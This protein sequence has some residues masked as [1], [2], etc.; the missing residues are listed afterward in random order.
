MKALTLSLIII[1]IAITGII[2][3]IVISQTI[4]H[5]TIWLSAVAVKGS[6]D[7]YTTVLDNATLDKIPVLKNAIDQARSGYLP[8]SLCIGYHG[9]P[10]SRTSTIQIR[11]SDVDSILQLVGNK[12][13]TSVIQENP[14]AEINFATYTYK[15]KFEFGNLSYNTTIEK[16]VYHNS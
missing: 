1:G 3:F 9:C 5:V 16:T 4:T 15:M 10:S 12:V 14:S 2:S 7:N 11:Q 13:K 6:D 8:P